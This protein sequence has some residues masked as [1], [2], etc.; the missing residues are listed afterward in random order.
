MIYL[1]LKWECSTLLLFRANYTSRAFCT[2]FYTIITQNVDA[3]KNNKDIYR[4]ITFTC[5]MA[6]LEMTLIK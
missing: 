4:L 3:I 5:C 2:Y 1:I 6:L